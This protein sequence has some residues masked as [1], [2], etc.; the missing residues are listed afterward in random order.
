[1]RLPAVLLTAALAGP[2]G[3]G[4]GVEL[5]RFA[6]AWATTRGDG[7][8]VAVVALD[9]ALGG[10]VGG[11]VGADA[12][13]AAVTVVTAAGEEALHESVDAVAGAGTDV[14]VL[15]LGETSFGDRLL[16]DPALGTAIGSASTAGAVVV[17]AAG[18]EAEALGPSPAAAGAVVVGGVTAAGQPRPY[19]NRS[20]LRTL[21]A[22]VDGVAGDDP[23]GGTS[24]AAGH[25]G[26]AAALLLAQGR[27][28]DDVAGVLVAT[29]VNPLGDARLGVGYLD[30]AAAVAAPIPAGTPMPTTEPPPV[31]DAGAAAAPPTRDRG[32]TATRPPPADPPPA[33][34][35]LGL[36][37]AVAA[38]VLGVDLALGRAAWRRRAWRA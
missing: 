13:E 15:A 30:A 23:L 20:L 3:A 28:P 2:T 19:A 22:P 1:M 34:G 9:P 12:P 5:P 35:P 24:V 18:S 29:A 7:V 21:G 37:A 38:G 8:S 33:T 36:A 11:V 16:A 6:E 26:A 25:V 4:P 31:V 17:A 10:H 27:G 32:A 14:V